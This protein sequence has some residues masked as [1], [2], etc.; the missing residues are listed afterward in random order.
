MD[1]MDRLFLIRLSTDMHL[2][3]LHLN[4]GNNLFHMIESMDDEQLRFYNYCGEVSG[5]HLCQTL[6]PLTPPPL[7]GPEF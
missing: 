3:R 5:G 2:L 7:L 6:P 4:T 1:L